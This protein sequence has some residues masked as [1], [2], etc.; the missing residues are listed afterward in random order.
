M[1]PVLIKLGPVTIHTYGFLFALGVL[2][3]ILLSLRLAK[4][5]KIETK[6]M[7]D[8]LFYVVLIALVG[9]KIFLFFTEFGY[10]LKHPGQIK[11]LITS[12]GTFYG[13]LIFAILFALWYMKKHGMNARV[14]GDVTGP[15][16]ALASLMAAS[17]S[18]TSPG[19]ICKINKCRQ[20]SSK[21]LIP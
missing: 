18:W 2:L 13:G 9:A 7:A 3:G 14:I 17:S 6:K 19:P 12:G 8:M 5:E 20:S 21:L 1:H 16:I 15:A 11:F 4:R 10:Y